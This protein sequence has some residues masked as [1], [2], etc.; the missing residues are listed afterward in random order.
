MRPAVLLLC[1]LLSFTAPAVATEYRIN[2]MVTSVHDG[3]TFR[4]NG[5]S[6]RL[7]GV[8]AVELTDIGGDAARAALASLINGQALS[9]VIKGKSYRRVVAQCFMGEYDIGRVLTRQGYA[10]DVV[11]FSRGYYKG[12]EA[13][14][15][16]ARTGLWAL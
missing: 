7:W 8:D 13:A 16:H 9:C 6:I 4:L 11:R 3:D 5:Q 14:A 1:L 12:D 10:Q 2:G 15:R